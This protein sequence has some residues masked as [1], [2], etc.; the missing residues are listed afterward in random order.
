MLNQHRMMEMQR[1]RNFQLQQQMQQNQPPPPPKKT[2]MS[3]IKNILSNLRDQIKGPIIV[4][5]LFLVLNHSI[6]NKY[7]VK[8]IPKIGNGSGGMNM[9][10]LILKSLLAGI[11]FYLLNT[12]I[13]F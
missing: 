3:N 5:V 6:V 9:K 7:L 11:I 2:L 10:G 12:F 4:I 8:F 1:A 13:N